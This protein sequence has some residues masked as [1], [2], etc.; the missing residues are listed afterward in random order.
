MLFEVDRYL[1]VPP[2]DFAKDGLHG[3]EVVLTGEGVEQAVVVRL[4]VVTQADDEA[5][6]AA[7]VVHLVTHRTVS[8]GVLGMPIGVSLEQVQVDGVPGREDVVQVELRADVKLIEGAVGG[9]RTDL[10]AQW[11]DGDVGLHVPIVAVHGGIDEMV[12]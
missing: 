1:I 10:A 5:I 11:M 8:E 3:V 12:S 4:V 6:H 2:I 9:R 7:I